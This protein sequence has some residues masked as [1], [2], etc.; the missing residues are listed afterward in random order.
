MKYKVMTGLARDPFR[1]TQLKGSILDND[2]VKLSK[3]K[4]DLAISYGYIEKIIEEKVEVVKPKKKRT[5]KN[6]K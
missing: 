1:L 5:V 2:Q 6:K 4:I 3:E